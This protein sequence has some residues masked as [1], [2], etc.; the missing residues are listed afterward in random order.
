MGWLARSI[1][2]AN[3]CIAQENVLSSQAISSCAENE[4]FDTSNFSCQSCPLNSQPRSDKTGCDC[5][6]G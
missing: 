3:L 4:F 1:I 6:P 2:Y 5:N